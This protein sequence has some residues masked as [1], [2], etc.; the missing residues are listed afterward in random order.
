MNWWQVSD[1]GVHFAS[2][3]GLTSVTVSM[4]FSLPGAFL[5]GRLPVVQYW[6]TC[7]T[8]LLHVNRTQKLPGARVVLR[9]LIINV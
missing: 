8:F 2:V 9:M 4:S 3:Y 7:V 5:R 1:L 6:V